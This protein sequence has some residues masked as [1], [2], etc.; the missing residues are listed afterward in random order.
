MN[1]RSDERYQM[2]GT[3]TSFSSW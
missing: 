1:V 3:E 2:P